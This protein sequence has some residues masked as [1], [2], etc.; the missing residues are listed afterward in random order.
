[1]QLKRVIFIATC[2]K[3]STIYIAAGQEPRKI[4]G[5]RIFNVK[6]FSPVKIAIEA[7]PQPPVYLERFG[8]IE[9]TDIRADSF[10]IGLRNRDIKIKRR[11]LQFENGLTNELNAYIAR[12]TNVSKAGDAP[13]LAIF[14]KDVWLRESDM[15]E[16]ENDK[17]YHDKDEEVQFTK[18]TLTFQADCFIRKGDGYYAAMRF[19]TTISKLL[20]AT[21]FSKTYFDFILTGLF[22]RASQLDPA[23]IISTKTKRNFNEIVSHYR[24]RWQIPVLT[25][26]VLRKGVYATFEEF[27]A[28]NPSMPVFEMKKSK[29]A[30]ILYAG[31]NAKDLQPTRGVWGYCDGK[32]I[33]IKAGENYYPM[34][35][36]QDSYY[37]LGST[38]VIYTHTSGAAPGNPYGFES[39]SITNPI[40]P[41]KLNWQSGKPY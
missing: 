39:S 8:K 36:Y 29:L 6:N 7:K 35:R 23:S 30:D 31:T 14:I 32:Y 40:Y 17:M 41:L 5:D 28:N 38:E 3:L 19:D 1:M 12:N 22:L 34:V 24:E 11:N 20:N 37:F 2:I 13:A 25:D 26:S 4:D 10:A 27:K 21:A 9:V 18:S 16:N 33:F 15:D